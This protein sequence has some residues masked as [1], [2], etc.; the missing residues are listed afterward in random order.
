MKRAKV[1]SVFAGIVAMS[2]GLLIEV[3][4]IDEDLLGKKEKRNECF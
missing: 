2:A 4:R 1:V 3:E